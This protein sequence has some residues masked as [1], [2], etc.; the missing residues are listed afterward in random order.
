MWYIR[1]FFFVLI[2]AMLSCYV[3][4]GAFECANAFC[5]DIW[6]KIKS[7]NYISD[8]ITI[9]AESHRSNMISE[10]RHVLGSDSDDESTD[11]GIMLKHWAENALWQVVE[12]KAVLGDIENFCKVFLFISYFLCWQCTVTLLNV[13][14]SLNV[15]ALRRLSR[16]PELPLRSRMIAIG[17]NLRGCWSDAAQSLI[18]TYLSSKSYSEC[19]STC[20]WLW[21]CLI[22]RDYHQFK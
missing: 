16:M 19:L 7:M 17:D 6:D 8:S 4:E 13:M 11:E 12:A 20:L 1:R 22:N 21:I 9:K 18:N 15:G 5:T 2:S 14:N 3:N 10:L